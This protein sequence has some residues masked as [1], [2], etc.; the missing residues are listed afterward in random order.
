MLIIFGV[1]IFL[2]FRIR[3]HVVVQT[4]NIGKRRAHIGAEHIL[5]RLQRTKMHLSQKINGV[6]GHYVP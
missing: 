2:L 6:E 3:A 1:K 5:V 4:I